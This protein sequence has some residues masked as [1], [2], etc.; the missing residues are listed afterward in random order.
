M[1]R[2]LIWLACTATAVTAATLFEVLVRALSSE[3]FIP[4]PVLDVMRALLL[5][6]WIMT[7]VCASTRLILKTLEQVVSKLTSTLLSEMEMQCERILDV[8][9]TSNKY[10]VD[11]MMS[12][13]GWKK[14][15][16][17]VRV[18]HE[19]PYRTDANRVIN[20]RSRPATDSI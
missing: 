3:S 18:D 5:G 7:G 12:E 9:D 2:L 17:P 11:K 8:V 16:K 14:T 13:F 6:L 10:E 4:G 15:A 20:F 1:S 19:S